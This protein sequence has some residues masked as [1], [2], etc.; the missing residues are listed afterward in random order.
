MQAVL[1]AVVAREVAA[2]LC[3]GYNVVRAEGVS[4]V[5]EGNG[6]HGRATVLEGANDVAEGRDD[7][8]VERSRKVLLYAGDF[9]KS[10]NGAGYCG[11]CEHT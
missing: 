5:W 1:D 7:G 11:H 9:I 3:A 4:G 8:T 2:R 10:N 6:E